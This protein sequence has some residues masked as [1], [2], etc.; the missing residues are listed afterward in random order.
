M[1]FVSVKIL[2]R[3]LLPIK[4]ETFI[5]VLRLKLRSLALGLFISFPSLPFFEFW[6]TESSQFYQPLSPCL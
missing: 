2:G 5:L 1:K 6:Q 3:V 4:M